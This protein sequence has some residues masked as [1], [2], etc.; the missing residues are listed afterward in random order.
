MG[1]SGRGRKGPLALLKQGLEYR[2]YVIAGNHDLLVQELGSFAVSGSGEDSVFVDLEVNGFRFFLIPIDN[3]EEILGILNP[4]P[5]H[6]STWL[7]LVSSWISV[8]YGPVVSGTRILKI[9]GQDV[10]YNEGRFRLL[11]RSYPVITGQDG[12]AP[13]LRVELLPQWHH[14]PPMANLLPV[15]PQDRELA[16]QLFTELGGIVNLD[17]KKALVIIGDDPTNSWSDHERDGGGDEVSSPNE[18]SEEHTSE[19]QSH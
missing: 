17:G 12:V 2:R 19:L 9:D 8:A 1:G 15:N 16:G 14:S 6:D 4:E 10:S 13:F 3:V 11:V 18:R 7:G 5:I